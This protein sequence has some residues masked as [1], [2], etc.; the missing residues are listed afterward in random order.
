MRHPQN[1]IVYCLLLFILQTYCG[2][3]WAQDSDS[4]SPT[5]SHKRKWLVAGG[6][7]AM[8]TGTYIALDKAWYDG[9][10]KRGFHLF[11]DGKEWNQMDKL[12]HVWTAYQL[13]RASGTTWQWAGIKP[14]TAT[15]LGGASAVAFQSI[16]EL[17]DAYSDKWGFSWWDMASNIVG[18]GAYV[19][20][21]LTWGEQRI[22][23]KMGYF[24]QD[25][26]GELVSRRNELFGK[27]SV[28]RILKDYNG[29][30]YWASINLRSFMPETNI[31]R[32]LNLAV[33]YSSDLMVGGM[34]NTFTDENGELKNYNSID[35]T[36]RIY[37][38]AD[39]DLTRIVT[40][41][42]FLRTI[43][44]TIN[45]IKIPAPAIELNSRSQLR[46]HAIHH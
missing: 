16:I 5:L 27:G 45:A 17:Q 40:R 41:S 44:F 28:E 46:L 7:A 10:E 42:K 29:Q 36:R 9:Y 34:D 2:S 8:W 13:A 38:S 3:I 6:H 30:T 43:F 22:Q 19:A 21:Q 24:P 23:V 26:P 32:W 20:Q 31:P 4:L 35:R 25:Y 33:G 18:S 1:I 14:S 37:L 39:V 12:G 11:D 15:W